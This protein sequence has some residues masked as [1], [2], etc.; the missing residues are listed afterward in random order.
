MNGN[1]C[2]ACA[3]KH[4]NVRIICEY[5][6]LDCIVVMPTPF[7]HRS[8]LNVGRRVCQ[9]C[10]CAS[11]LNRNNMD[12]DDDDDNYTTHIILTLIL[13]RLAFYVF[14]GFPL[15]RTRALSTCVCVCEWVNCLMNLTHRLIYFLSLYCRCCRLPFTA[16]A[17]CSPIAIRSRTNARP[18]DVAN[19]IAM[20]DRCDV[21]PK[22]IT[23]H[24]R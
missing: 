1:M 2:A 6:Y 3:R 7:A 16:M 10:V 13:L 4:S 21:I 17:I 11:M 9:L 19:H 24:W 12:D 20:P 8:L 14:I 22:I 23:V 5:N 18:K 15:A